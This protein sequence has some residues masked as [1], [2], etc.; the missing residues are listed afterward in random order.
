METLQQ[1]Q[2]WYHSQCNLDWEHTYG[3]TIGTLDNPGW[4]VTVDL[5]ETERDGA[6]FEP[7]VRGDSEGTDWVHC[8]VENKQFQGAGGAL[9]LEEIL[10]VF[11]KWADENVA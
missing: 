3:I 9:N 7:F 1:L 8:K 11:L 4:L 6:A 10:Q 2:A 5:S